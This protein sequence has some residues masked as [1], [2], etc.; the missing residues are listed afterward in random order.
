MADYDGEME[1]IRESQ[2]SNMK[3]M[4]YWF[5]HLFTEQLA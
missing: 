3:L 4:K 1:F 2:N 5:K